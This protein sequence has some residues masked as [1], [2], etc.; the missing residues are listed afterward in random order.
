MEGGDQGVCVTEQPEVISGD[1]NCAPLPDDAPSD[2]IGPPA[3]GTLYT[4]QGEGNGWFVTDVV[5][6]GKKIACMQYA[7]DPAPANPTTADCVA[8]PFAEIAAEIPHPSAC[9]TDATDVDGILR[10]CA[11][12]CGY[13]ACKIAS[14]KIRATADALEIPPGLEQIP[15][16]RAKA[17]LYAFA[18]VLESREGLGYCA[19]KTAASP[20]EIV[21]IDLGRGVSKQGAL[22]HI[23]SAQIYLSCTFDPN[24]PYTMDLDA[25]FCTDPGNIP[26]SEVGYVWQ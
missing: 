6:L 1:A 18:T 5:G 2:E 3:P 4:C 21:A 14:A 11:V 10:T 16:K 17:D 20:G 7:A 9:C 13:A 26:T 15:Y 8:V 19:S 22:G 12:D 25:P 24:Q 23:Q